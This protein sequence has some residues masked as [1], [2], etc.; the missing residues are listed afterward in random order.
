MSS[1]KWNARYAYSGGSIP[2]PAEVLSRGARFLPTN[3]AE[4]TALDLAC[5]RAGNGEWLGARGFQV[6]TWDVSEAA[7]DI[8]RARASGNIASSQVRDVV[9]NPPA[10]ATFDVIVVSRFLD[11]SVCASLAA[12]L[13]P[14]GLLYY[15]TFTHGLSNP[16]YL[17]GPNELLSLFP[18][19]NV[20]WYD[21]PEPDAKGRAEA[22]LIARASNTF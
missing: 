17:L 10:A 20:C 12:A 8:I 16:D 22:K 9:L 1:S 19:L 5:G 4:L 7:I 3:A 13:K 2:P 11:R 21:E 18:S 15:Q 6:S 14:H